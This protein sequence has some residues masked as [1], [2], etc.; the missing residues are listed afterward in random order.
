MPPLALYSYNSWCTCHC[1]IHQSEISHFSFNHAAIRYL[2]PPWPGFRLVF[3]PLRNAPIPEWCLNLSGDRPL[4]S[5]L[6]EL[7]IN[8]CPNTISSLRL[9]KH[10]LLSQV[11]RSTALTLPLRSRQCR[12]VLL[13]TGMLRAILLWM[14]ITAVT[15]SSARHVL[16]ALR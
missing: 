9:S 4:V 6:V 13:S 15:S 12:A 14:V 8:A 16:T 11:G 5:L 1:F 7:L 3:L 10:H 2:A